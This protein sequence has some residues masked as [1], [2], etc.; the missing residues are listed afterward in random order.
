M[1]NE[2]ETTVVNT[3]KLLKAQDVR[4]KLMKEGVHYGKVVDK[5]SD[6][7]YLSGASLLADVFEI[8]GI[9]SDV[10]EEQ[11]D[12]QSQITVVIDMVDR[13]SGN[14]HCVGVGTW[15]SGEM[16]GNMKGAR[17]RG[18]AMAYKRAY[19]MGV[20]YA[21][22]SH[23]M[24]SQDKDVVDSRDVVQGTTVPRQQTSEPTQAV[25]TD[26]GEKVSVPLEMRF[27][28]NRKE[29]VFTKFGAKAVDKTI[30]E[31]MAE[32]KGF[33]EWMLNLGSN[34]SKPDETPISMDL[35]TLIVKT[36]KGEL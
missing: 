29:L 8:D 20:R 23:G 21:T 18:I 22:S 7:L 36:L 6:F 32:N 31:I 24:F 14:R 5:Q 4:D 2:N 30:D 33:L 34:P 12:G 28:E 17:Q 25:D 1:T 13:E 19:V 10:R 16:L 35:R 3:T 11:V 27:D 26:T 15:D 9:M